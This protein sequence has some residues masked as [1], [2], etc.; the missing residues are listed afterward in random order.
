MSRT[1]SDVSGFL[2]NPLHMIRCLM[3]DPHQRQSWDDTL[4]ALCRLLADC[5]ADCRRSR[6]AAL[7]FDEET[8]DIISLGYNGLASKSGS[9]LDGD[10]PRGLLPKQEFPSLGPYSEGAGRCDAV[11]AEANA[12]LRAGRSARNKTLYVTGK[13]CHGCSIL[14]RGAGITRIVYP[15]S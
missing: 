4:I 5:R 15:D 8:Q 6:H 1:A 3:I 7:I 2:P 12:L 13:P 11:H 9:C 14:I 10:C